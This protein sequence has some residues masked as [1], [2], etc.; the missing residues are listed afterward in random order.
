M[1]QAGGS[2]WAQ[3][4][5]NHLKAEGGEAAAGFLT[6]ESQ[7]MY[8]SGTN[9]GVKTGLQPH[10]RNESCSTCFLHQTPLICSNNQNQ[11]RQQAKTIS[12]CLCPYLSSAWRPPCWP[13]RPRRTAL[14]RS[15]RWSWPW[16]R[17]SATPPRLSPTTKTPSSPGS[18]RCAPSWGQNQIHLLLRPGSVSTFCVLMNCFLLFGSLNLSP[19]LNAL[20]FPPGRVPSPDRFI[21]L[22]QRE[23]SGRWQAANANSRYLPVGFSCVRC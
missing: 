9:A 3:V 17:W 16:T 14:A 19:Q 4:G 12:V 15:S 21:V 8:L 23:T 20:R 11:N 2:R 6:A 18:S 10:F 5:L 13:V 1:R 7:N 22:Q